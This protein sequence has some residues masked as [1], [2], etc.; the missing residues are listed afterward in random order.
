MS[1]EG[2]IYLDIKYTSTRG[3]LYDFVETISFVLDIDNSIQTIIKKNNRDTVNKNI[4]QTLGLKIGH[5][6]I[7]NGIIAI[8]PKH[9]IMKACIDK[10]VSNIVNDSICSEHLSSLFGMHRISGSEMMAEIIKNN[11]NGLVTTKIVERPNNGGQ[12]YIDSPNKNS[13]IY[14]DNTNKNTHDYGEAYFT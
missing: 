8:T 13:Q 6:R 14:T 5:P 1:I 12:F 2:G 3:G 10:T 7:F 11:S 4:E 9:E